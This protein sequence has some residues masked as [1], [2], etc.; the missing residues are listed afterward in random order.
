M[1]IV[2]LLDI[3]GEKININSEVVTSQPHWF[4]GSQLYISKFSIFNNFL[5]YCPIFMKLAPNS[6]V[7]EILPLWAWFYCF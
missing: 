7:L 1:N 3:I 4:S 2:L 5:V 6:L